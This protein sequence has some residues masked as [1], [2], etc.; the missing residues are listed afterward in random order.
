MFIIEPIEVGPL[1]S[2]CETTARSQYVPLHI[3]HTP[4]PQPHYVHFELN[5]T[6]TPIVDRL[7]YRTYREL[8]RNIEYVASYP[9]NI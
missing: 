4:T 6:V 3:S 7:L 1:P 8:E 2:G 9:K 5:V